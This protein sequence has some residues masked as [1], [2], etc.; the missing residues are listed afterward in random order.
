MLLFPLR[1]KRLGWLLL[2]SAAALLFQGVNQYSSALAMFLGA[3]WWLMAFKLASDALVDTAFG[4]DRDEGGAGRVEGKAARQIVLAAGLLGLM[5]LLGFLAGPSVQLAACV[6]LALLLPAMAIVLVLENSLLRA[7]DPSAWYQLLRRVGSR[8]LLLTLKL[9]ALGAVLALAFVF[10][11]ASLPPWLA[12]TVMH[13]LALYCLLAG[14]HAMGALVHRRR[15]AFEAPA[16]QT[17]F[18]PPPVLDG[19]ELAWQECE[20]LVAGGRAD[21]GAAVLGRFIEVGNASPAL[22]A[23][24]RELLTGLGDNQGL[25]R[26]SHDY[27]AVLLRQGKER[28]AMAL[29]LASRAMYGD[30]E[31]QDAGL[32]RELIAVALRNQQDKLAASLAEE[33][34]RKFPAASSSRPMADAD[35]IDVEPGPATGGVR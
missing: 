5:W 30:F 25:L 22:H 29:Y 23:R 31:L 14:Y 15:A 9:T 13:F 20:R 11:L 35:I 19:E 24:Y 3:L 6:G 26:H 28:E 12:T 17:S 1:G 10:L 27:V 4:H 21:E 34:A 2:M 8:Y 18:A 33:L 32:L 16:A 7:I